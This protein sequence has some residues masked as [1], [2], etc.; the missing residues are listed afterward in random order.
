MKDMKRIFPAF[1]ALILTVL[2]LP[3]VAMAWEAGQVRKVSDGDTLHVGNARVRL[4]GIDCPEKDQP[5]GQKAKDFVTSKIV[6]AGG[7][8]FLDVIDKDHYGRLVAVVRLGKPDGPVLNQELLRAGLAWYY[9]RYC[10][11]P[12]CEAWKETE[13]SA[14]TAKAGLWGQPNPTAPWNWRRKH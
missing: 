6:Q 1:I 13:A 3:V 7:Q 11:T 5:F 8:V 14:R 2:V 9:T 12:T 10:K 4:Y